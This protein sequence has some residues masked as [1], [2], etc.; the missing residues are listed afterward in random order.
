MVLLCHTLSSHTCLSHTRVTPAQVTLESRPSHT[1][2][3]HTRSSHTAQVTLALTVIKGAGDSAAIR[4]GL[5]RRRS[6]TDRS[7]EEPGGSREPSPG[8]RGLRAERLTATS[9][10][11]TAGWPRLKVRTEPRLTCQ[12][13]TALER[14]AHV[15]RCFQA[16]ISRP[17]PSD[18]SLQTDTC[19]ECEQV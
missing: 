7:A 16:A 2:L 15:L 4:D 8:A 1:R 18:K 19:S 17:R 3:S 6:E 9:C 13:C 11:T 12:P 10:C 5:Q 14:Q